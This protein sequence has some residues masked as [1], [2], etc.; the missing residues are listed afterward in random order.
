MADKSKK[1]RE[2]K[3][4][5]EFTRNCNGNKI[6]L[7]SLDKIDN[8]DWK[9]LMLL[10]SLEKVESYIYLFIVIWN[11]IP[12]RNNAEFSSEFDKETSE[13][14]QIIEKLNISGANDTDYS[15]VLDNYRNYRYNNQDLRQKIV[16]N[17][18]VELES[19]G[20]KRCSHAFEDQL[21]RCSIPQKKDLRL[22]I[23]SRMKLIQK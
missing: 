10:A 16:H 8:F 20:F 21:K 4:N 12:V 5:Q 18:W 19:R 11:T 15:K 1:Q 2:L 3:G 7:Y 14:I 23:L 6:P 9:L 22:M 13:M 17:S